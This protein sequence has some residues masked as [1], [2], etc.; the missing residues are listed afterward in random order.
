MQSRNY[1]SDVQFQEVHEIETGL[2]KI[3]KDPNDPLGT[4]LP[5]QHN[6]RQVHVRLLAHVKQSLLSSP[7]TIYA[8]VLGVACLGNLA[9]KLCEG[10]CYC[11][12]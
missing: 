9:Y 5:S 11:P 2:L 12:F 4:H 1:S 8:R 6:G 10:E 3:P 7:R